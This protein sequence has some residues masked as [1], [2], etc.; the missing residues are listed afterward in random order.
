M[1]ATRR[2]ELWGAH[3]S[4]SRPASGSSAAPWP[5]QFSPASAGATPRGPSRQRL[6]AG[7]G[8]VAPR[9]PAIHWQDTF[10][11]NAAGQYGF[12]APPFGEGTWVAYG[13]T[14]AAHV[15]SQSKSVCDKCVLDIGNT[16]RIMVSQRLVGRGTPPPARTWSPWRATR[17]S[18]RS[19]AP[20]SAAAHRSWHPAKFSAA[21]R[22]LPMW[23]DRRRPSCARP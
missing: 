13:Q 5:R 2:T 19:P 9:N 10:T 22:A 14:D 4:R 17:C 21:G 7:Q 6:A 3:R 12:Y 16:R 1:G 18:V 20:P 23:G 8:P 15:Y 11:T